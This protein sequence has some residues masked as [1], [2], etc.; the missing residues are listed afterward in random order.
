MKQA[1]AGCPDISGGV[2]LTARPRQ[3]LAT[4]VKTYHSMKDFSRDNVNTRT[5]TSSRS[6]A[7]CDNSPGTVARQ[8]RTELEESDTSWHAR[9]MHPAADQTLTMSRVEVVDLGTDLG[10]GHFS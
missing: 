10:E 8:V 7:G 3:S 4:K 1:H 2:R 6:P 9:V 5:C